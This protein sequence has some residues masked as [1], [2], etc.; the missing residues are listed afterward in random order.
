MKLARVQRVCGEERKTF[1]RFFWE[2]SSLSRKSES[3]QFQF[4]VDSS[5]L[6]VFIEEREEFTKHSRSQRVKVEHSHVKIE[7]KLSCVGGWKN[8]DKQIKHVGNS[9]NLVGIFPLV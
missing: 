5:L 1:L 6:L 9:R 8:W 2:Q 7:N 4:K 3:R